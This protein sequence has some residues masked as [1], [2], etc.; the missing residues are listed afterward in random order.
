M[1]DGSILGFLEIENVA[2]G[3]EVEILISEEGCEE[4]SGRSAGF[5]VDWEGLKKSRMDLFPGGMIHLQ[6]EVAL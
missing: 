1:V 3:R 5:D 4:D 2:A 6:W